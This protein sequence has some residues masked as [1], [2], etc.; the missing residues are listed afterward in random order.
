MSTETVAPTVASLAGRLL[1]E[2]VGPDEDYPDPVERH[3]MLAKAGEVLDEA[4]RLVRGRKAGCA[5]ELA[6]A[7][8][9]HEEVARVL[10]LG[11]RQRAGLLI[12]RARTGPG[13]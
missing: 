1:D 10:G 11:T 12:A 4:L 7:G 3:R 5:A 13:R 2:F 8:L 9:R 6:A